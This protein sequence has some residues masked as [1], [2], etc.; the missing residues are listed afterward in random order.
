MERPCGMLLPPADPGLCLTYLG[1]SG[2]A[3]YSGGPFE[4]SVPS[5]GSLPSGHGSGPYCS[6]QGA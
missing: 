5:S 1:G 3:S 2:S 4:E 6:A